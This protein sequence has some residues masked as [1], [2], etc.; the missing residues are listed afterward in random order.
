MPGAVVRD[1]VAS[2]ACLA[3]VKKTSLLATP[4]ANKPQQAQPGEEILRLAPNPATE[5]VNVEVRLETA[6]AASVILLDITGRPLQ[7]RVLVQ[8]RETVEFDLGKLPKGVYLVQIL[9][10]EKMVAMK[11]LVKN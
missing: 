3:P 5:L 6:N 11:R 1:R 10:G 7:T 4:R 8:R 2:A 9:E